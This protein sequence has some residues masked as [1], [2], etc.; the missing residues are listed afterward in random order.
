LTTADAL[1]EIPGGYAGLDWTNWV[2][3]HQTLYGSIGMFNGVV[4]PEHF[5]YNSSGHPAT[6][7]SDRGF[8]FGGVFLSVARPDAEQHEILIR[9]WRHDREA[10]EDRITGTTAGPIYFDADYRNVTRAEFASEAYWQ[11]VIDDLEFRTDE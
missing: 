4:S 8:D 7:G 2:A 6:F 9:A 11:I 3:M 1:F 5:A 10:Y